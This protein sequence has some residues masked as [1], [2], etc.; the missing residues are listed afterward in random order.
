MII[1]SFFQT[2]L[3]V[4]FIEFF[5]V[6]YIIII[7][8]YYYFNMIIKRKHITEIVADYHEEETRYMNSE[9]CQLVSKSK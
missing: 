8:I 4:V 6:L 5:Y 2:E 9:K 7:I 1:L 3:A